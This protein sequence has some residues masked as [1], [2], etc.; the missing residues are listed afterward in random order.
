VGFFQQTADST[1]F[2][3]RQNLNIWLNKNG[4]DN[5][6]QESAVFIAQQT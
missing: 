1:T 4:L 5:K 2:I 3:Y 6:K